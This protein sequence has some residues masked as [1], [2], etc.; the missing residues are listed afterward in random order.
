M[1]YYEAGHM[2]Y[3]H[4]PSLEQL[5]KDTPNFADPNFAQIK[6]VELKPI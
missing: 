3:I 2:M 6:I 1:K 4:H 5:A